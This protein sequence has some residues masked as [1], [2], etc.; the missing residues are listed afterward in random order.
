MALM[1]QCKCFSISRNH[2]LLPKFLALQI[3]Q[4]SDMMHF[5][6]CIFRTAPFTFICRN[7]LYQ[8][9]P[10]KIYLLVLYQIHICIF[11]HFF[12]PKALV[13]QQTDFFY[14]VFSLVL[15]SEILAYSHFIH[16][17]AFCSSIFRCICFEHAVFH[18]II[19]AVYMSTV[20][21]D[22]I[23]IVKASDFRIVCSENFQGTY[24]HCKESDTVFHTGNFGLCCDWLDCLTP[25]QD[26]S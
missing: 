13:I 26:F 20:I 11:V 2:K 21:C 25:F 24:L 22:R 15:D 12:P 17:T 6:R 23:I 5:N 18:N 9:R 3:L 14:S 19:E 7:P 10:F 4:L 16:D 8:A 1:T